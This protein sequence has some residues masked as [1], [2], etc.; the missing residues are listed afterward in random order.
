MPRPYPNRRRRRPGRRPPDRFSGSGGG[1]A[2]GFTPPVYKA[3]YDWL[4]PGLR[5]AGAKCSSTRF[6]AGSC[7][8]SRWAGRCWAIRGWACSA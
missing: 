7:S 4:M 5:G 3:V 8:R 2:P 1:P 6:P